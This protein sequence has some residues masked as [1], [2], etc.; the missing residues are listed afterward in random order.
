MDDS[1]KR[2][3]A[4]VLNTIDGQMVFQD[5]LE[6]FQLASGVYRFMGNDNLA[7]LAF[8]DGQRNA[9]IYIFGILSSINPEKISLINTNIM[10]KQNEIAFKNSQKVNDDE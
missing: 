10:K 4:N 8:R 3:Y 1:V 6:K 9:G 5:L 7:D 2:A